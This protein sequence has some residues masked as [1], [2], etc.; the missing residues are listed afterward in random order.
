MDVSHLFGSSVEVLTS[1]YWGDGLVS[2]V[3]YESTDVE[4]LSIDLR[5]GLGISHRVGG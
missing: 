2:G 3:Y 5:E 1:Q 4:A